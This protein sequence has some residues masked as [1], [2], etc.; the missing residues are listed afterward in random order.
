MNSKF[1]TEISGMNN[2]LDSIM[3]NIGDINIMAKFNSLEQNYLHLQQ[4]HH[5]LLE[6]VNSLD[7]LSSKFSDEYRNNMESKLM[8]LSVT[9]ERLE[10]TVVMIGDNKNTLN[11][12]IEKTDKRQNSLMQRELCRDNS[13]WCDSRGGQLGPGQLGPGDFTIGR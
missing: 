13:F 2:K 1:L 8:D 11:Q 6:R 10:K 9:K 4:E 5:T 3:N 12:L 7:S